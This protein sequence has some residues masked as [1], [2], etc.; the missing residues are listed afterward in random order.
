VHSSD[1]YVKAI[2][3]LFLESFPTHF[4]GSP[5]N[6]NHPVVLLKSTH[7]VMV[8]KQTSQYIMGRDDV[9]TVV[10]LQWTCNYVLP[11]DTSACEDWLIFR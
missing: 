9:R 1:F 6:R 10:S 4:P 3:N 5:T 8:G 2:S 11:P 7:L